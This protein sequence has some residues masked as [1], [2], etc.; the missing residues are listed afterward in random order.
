MDA[1]SSSGFAALRARA[2]RLANE[3][4]LPF[5]TIFHGPE[6]F[7]TV[8]SNALA[9]ADSYERGSGREIPL[10]VKQALSLGAYTHDAYHPGSTLR[11]DARY[12]LWLPKL[13]SRVASEW[14]T[15]VSINQFM[16]GQGLPLPARLFQMY[17]ILATT[18]GG[19]AP[20]GKQLGIPVPQPKSVWG[21]IIRASDICPPDR[22]EDWLRLTIAVNYGEVPASTAART[23]AEFVAQGA[24]F[25][26]YVQFCMDQMD[27]AAGFA[28]SAHL[29]WRRR[30]HTLSTGVNE[31]KDRSGRIAAAARSELAKY[32]VTLV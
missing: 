8:E 19:A 32:R 15:A 18:Y 25:A 22:F 24:S 13:G 23:W 10:A 17:I 31:L 20:K 11:I 4:V 6:H 26:N 28:L 16:R 2:V 30:L 21:T 14:V 12:G 3:S 1:L 7:G 9:A 5:K 27:T 29:G